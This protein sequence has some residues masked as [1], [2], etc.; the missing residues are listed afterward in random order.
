MDDNEVEDEEEKKEEDGA[1]TT[2]SR[3]ETAKEIIFSN[4]AAI[5]IN[6]PPNPVIDA[7]GARRG[8][9]GRHTVRY[10]TWRREKIRVSGIF[11]HPPQ[12]GLGS[13]SEKPNNQ[14]PFE[15]SGSIGNDCQSI[16]RVV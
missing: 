9:A 8:G 4:E 15:N 14:N 11:H 6:S 7:R 5:K 13:Q 16:P 10:Q 12:P 1:E 3:R 2:A